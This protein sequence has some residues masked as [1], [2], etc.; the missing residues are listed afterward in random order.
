[1]QIHDRIPMNRLIGFISRQSPWVIVLAFTAFWVAAYM[2]TNH[3]PWRDPA[4]LFFFPLEATIPFLGWTVPIYL[5]AFPQAASVVRLIDRENLGKTTVAAGGLVL[6]HTLIF[7]VFP[8]TYPRPTGLSISPPFLDL[9]YRLICLADSP[10][11]CFPS[12]HVSIA[13]LIAL[14][15]WRCRR[16]LGVA[17]L[18]W[19]LLIA[20]STLTTKQHYA[21]D[22]L[23]G[24]AL[25]V[26][27]YFIVF[28]GERLL[29]SRIGIAGTEN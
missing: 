1:M 15:I 9:L 20:I 11:N 28:R 2:T 27:A 19:A 13:T 23:A 18:C 29:N 14:V 10:R 4:R 25:A 7:A 17:F 24:T 5:S 26:L 21:L 8:T 6:I 16:R 22:V 3:L 12:L